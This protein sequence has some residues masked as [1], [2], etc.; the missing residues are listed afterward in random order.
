MLTRLGVNLG[1]FMGISL[2]AVVS[3]LL[4]TMDGP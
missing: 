2:W 3:V 1:S 4:H